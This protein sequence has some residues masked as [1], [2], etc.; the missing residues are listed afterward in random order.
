MNNN[1]NSNTII[2]GEE[3]DIVRLFT[4]TVDFFIRQ[5]K[6]FLTTFLVGLILSFSSFSLQKFVYKS[7]LIGNSDILRNE[8]VTLLFK[9][10][11]GMI[12]E[13]NI[14]GVAE[15]MPIS[16]DIAKKIVKIEASAVNLKELKDVS[17]SQS[18]VNTFQIDVLTLEPE[19]LDSIQI[20]IVFYLKNN[21]F[22]KKKVLLQE[23]YLKGMVSKIDLEIS[24]I[25]STRKKIESMKST[26]VSL[27]F[28]GINN[29]IVNLYEKRLLYTNQ[30]A[31]LND[32]LIIQD[33]VKYRKPVSPVLGI[34]LIGGISST[35]IF[36]LIWIAFSEI[37]RKYKQL[38]VK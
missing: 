8:Y 7:T 11:N 12:S 34:Y 2:N 25:D 38:N 26:F 14:E 4:K 27:D 5:Y 32:I 28:S 35:I 33:F 1:E 15:L 13:G 3:I 37:R 19:I 21:D 36:G 9:N 31:T 20:G 23:A 29:S 17:S 22:V 16:K 24:K 6:V 10:L 18:L 30:L